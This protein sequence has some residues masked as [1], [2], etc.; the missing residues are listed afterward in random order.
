MVKAYESWDLP[1][2]WYPFTIEL[3]DHRSGRVCWQTKVT[4][5]GVVDIPSTFMV[6][7]GYPVRV[8]ITIADGHSL[9]SAPRGDTA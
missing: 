4:G 2:E 8:R 3:V 5:V 7:D 6:N 9:E 1:A